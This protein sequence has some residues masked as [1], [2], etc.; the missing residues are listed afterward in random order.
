MTLKARVS[1][2]ERRSEAP[3]GVFI[4]QQDLDNRDLFHTPAGILT[5]SEVEAIAASQQVIML[6]YT[7]QWPP[8][9]GD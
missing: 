6:T 4:A 5:R 7:S 3:G 1:Q 8:G 2:L 9:R